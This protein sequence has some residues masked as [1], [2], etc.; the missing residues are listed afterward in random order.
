MR[1][2]PIL[3]PQAMSQLPTSKL[4]ACRWTP[5]VR[6]PTRKPRARSV[7]RVGFLIVIVVI[8]FGVASHSRECHGLTPGSDGSTAVKTHNN[9]YQVAS[10]TGVGAVRSASPTS[11]LADGQ[12]VHPRTSAPDGRLLPVFPNS[13]QA[14]AF[15]PTATAGGLPRCYRCDTDC[16]DSLS[17]GIR[18]H[19]RQYQTLVSSRETAV[20]AMYCRKYSQLSL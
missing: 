13:N 4:W 15:P 12:P 17:S 9:H 20:S 11:G 7:R 19:V 3:T 8:I 14:Y 18:H 2:Q 10:S 6:A 5:A 16:C 1:R